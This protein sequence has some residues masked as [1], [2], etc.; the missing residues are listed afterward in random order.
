[1]YRV[2][3]ALQNIK[4]TIKFHVS[5]KVPS[6]SHQFHAFNRIMMQGH[7]IENCFSLSWENLGYNLLLNPSYQIYQI[8]NNF[9]IFDTKT[10]EKNKC[11]TIFRL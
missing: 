1:M 5:Y 4:C 11:I 6:F 8:K 10:N 9:R 2:N 7:D 3:I